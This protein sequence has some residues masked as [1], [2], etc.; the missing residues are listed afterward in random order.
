MRLLQYLVFWRCLHLRTTWPQSSKARTPY[1]VCVEC[2]QE[3]VYDLVSWKRLKPVDSRR[4]SNLYGKATS[5][6]RQYGQPRRRSKYMYSGYEVCSGNDCHCDHHGG[7][8]WRAEHVTLVEAYRS[9][10]RPS[11]YRSYVVGPYGEREIT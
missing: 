8:V 3:F 9:L 1:V 11:G 4:T 7:G 10:Y 5:D 2:G 6:R